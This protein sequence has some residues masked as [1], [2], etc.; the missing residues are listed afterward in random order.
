MERWF[1]EFGR[2]L[3][4]ENTFQ[5]SSP[6][7]L[8]CNRI[9]ETENIFEENPQ[10]T[11]VENIFDA[12]VWPVTLIDSIIVRKHNRTGD[13]VIEL[14]KTESVPEAY[15]KMWLS[16]IPV[17]QQA[18]R[19][20]GA[21][22]HSSLA[23]YKGRGV[24][25][26]APG[27]TGKSTSV[28]RLPASWEA[29]CDDE[30]MIMPSANGY[31]AHPFPTWSE[32]LANKPRRVWNPQQQVSLVRIYFLKH[33]EKD[34]IEALGKSEAAALIN[35]A[36]CQVFEKGITRM[37]KD[38]ILKLKSEVFGRACELARNV[39]CFILYQSLEGEFWRLLERDIDGDEIQAGD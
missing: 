24:L 4:L 33:A 11:G 17:Y 2:I 32:Y 12:E 30:A 29:L 3:S 39:N 7:I 21:P 16:L 5:L 36:C 26:A 15:Y 27:G 34:R 1:N 19:L 13:M 35:Q 23:S 22:L 20:G 37:A 14:R 10:F 8:Y 6:F 38:D 28:R 31:T 18:M 25:F 9:E